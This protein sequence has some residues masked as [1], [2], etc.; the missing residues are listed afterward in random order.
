M[1]G[2]LVLEGAAEGAFATLLG[3]AVRRRGP[4]ERFPLLEERPRMGDDRQSLK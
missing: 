3:A 2:T 1:A 4:P